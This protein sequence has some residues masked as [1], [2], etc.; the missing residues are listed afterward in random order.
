MGCVSDGT[1][2]RRKE[3]GGEAGWEPEGAAACGKVSYKSI[4]IVDYLFGD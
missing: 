4:K 1:V 3:S 2:S